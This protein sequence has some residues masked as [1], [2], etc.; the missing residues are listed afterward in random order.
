MPH[1]RGWLREPCSLSRSTPRVGGGNEQ[2]D[3]DPSQA[4]VV[5]FSVGN[6]I[7]AAC[8]HGEQRVA[9]EVTAMFKGLESAKLAESEKPAEEQPK[10]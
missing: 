7:F 8:V 9:A 4:D 1:K 10:K 2:D 6:K 3:R 5:V